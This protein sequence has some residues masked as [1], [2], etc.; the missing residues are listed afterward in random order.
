MI[1]G[2]TAPLILDFSGQDV[3]FN[4]ADV[5]TLR[6]TLKQ[7]KTEVTLTPR[8]VDETTL[9]VS[10]TQLQ[11]LSFVLPSSVYPLQIQVNF[12]Q[13]GVRYASEVSSIKV[14]LQLLDEVI[15]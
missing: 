15:E 13:G 8:V 3:N 12:L 10:L 14:G 1:R 11:S 5:G 4:L 7:A 2:T 9:E 6:V